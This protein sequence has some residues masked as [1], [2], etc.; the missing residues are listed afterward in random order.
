VERIV[1]DEE[2]SGGGGKSRSGRCRGRQD[3]VRAGDVRLD[4]AV[5]IRL[6]DLARR[7]ERADDGVAVGGTVCLENVAVLAEQRAPP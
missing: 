3:L 6:E 2:G 1:I 5:H 4:V 7:L